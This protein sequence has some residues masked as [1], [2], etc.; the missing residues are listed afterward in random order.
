MSGLHWT[1]AVLPVALLLLGYPFFVILLVAATASLL[2]VLEL[3]P[4]LIHQNIFSSLNRYALIAIPFF[5]F[6][7]DL[8]ARGGI[9]Q[10]LVRWVGSLIGG[11]RGY[12]PMTALG[13]TVVFGTISGSTTAAV[14]AVG[15]MTYGRLREAGYSDRYASGLIVSAA[16]IDNLIP[17]SV[18]FIL[19]SVAS[20]TSLLRL[21]T[22]GIV[23]GLLLGAAFAVLIYLH[24]V[25]RGERPQ[26]R[27]TWAEFAAATRHGVWSVLAPV[28]VLGGLYAG[29]F[30]P[31][32]AAGIACVYA[33]F[34]VGV[35][36]REM[37][38]REIFDSAARTAVLTAQIFIIVAMAGVYSWLLTV[39]GTSEALA[40]FISALDAP[41]FAVLLAINVLLIMIGT[42]IDTA[43][44]ILLMTPL[45]VPI[46][47]AIGIDPIHFGVILVMNLSLG[48]FTPPF[49]LNL[50]VAQAVFRANLR[51]M[52]LGVVP[53][54]LVALVV[55]Q[56]VTYIPALSLWAY[57]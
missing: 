17:P 31:T 30:S 10:R 36:H 7:G 6:A 51:E 3:P 37:G 23:P 57:R 28:V 19:Y 22:A 24:A 49:G 52:Y 8:M 38:W 39:S 5:V 40:Q 56:L 35:V 1:L 34:V 20:Q 46:A 14:A 26:Q 54:F 48:T 55:L 50:F 43:S 9:S 33:L 25:K 41:P 32:E 53:F 21:F 29:M 47:L 2:L 16:A 13:T 45:L 12:L 27:F 15:S 18:G 42:C 44:A 11:T 4:E